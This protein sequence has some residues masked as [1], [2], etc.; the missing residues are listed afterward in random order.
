LIKFGPVWTNFILF[1]PDNQSDAI[2]S[3]FIWF[4]FSKVRQN[5]TTWQMT[6]SLSKQGLSLKSKAFKHQKNKKLALKLG[7]QTYISNFDKQW[8]SL[9]SKSFYFLV[10]S[11]L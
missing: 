9:Y 1:Q 7:I 8:W 6:R 11:Y 4:E 2:W 5:K 3:N 10:F